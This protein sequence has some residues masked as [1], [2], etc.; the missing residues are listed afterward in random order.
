M[1]AQIGSKDINHQ[2]YMEVCAMVSGLVQ[3]FHSKKPP[4]KSR[5]FSGFYFL[6]T[7]KVPRRIIR[8]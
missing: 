5:D 6:F 1:F 8:N 4:A 3:K 7:F 2:H